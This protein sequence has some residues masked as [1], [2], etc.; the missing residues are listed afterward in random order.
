MLSF[1][2][3]VAVIIVTICVFLFVKPNPNAKTKRNN[4]NTAANY[5]NRFNELIKQY[6]QTNNRYLMELQKTERK[7][8]MCNDFDAQKQF[9]TITFEYERT[10]NEANE[11]INRCRTC[12]E[13]KDFA[14]SG[15]CME[16]LLS[17]L[18]SMDN[19]I[20]SLNNITPKHNEYQFHKQSDID[21]K[22]TETNAPFQF[23]IGCKTKEEADVRYRSL[24]KAFHPDSKGGDETMFL[25]M[26]KEYE[27][28]RW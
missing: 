9:E 6:N 20:S 5:I 18:T 12:I 15:Y 25:R 21:T 28:L 22:T 8:V 24:A 11:Y 3:I 4:Y 26:Q 10:C 16:Q 23:F 19:I 1:F 7:I 14:G 27:A 17:V 2:I 13:Q